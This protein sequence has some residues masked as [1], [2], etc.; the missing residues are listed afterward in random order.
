MKSFRL[1]NIKAFKDS[2]EIELK[3]ITI[4]VGKNSCGK[5][6]LLRFP[7]VLSQTVKE[8]EK[9][10]PVSFYGEL[11]DY[12][13]LEDI[14]HGKTGKEIAFSVSYILDVSE[15]SQIV[16]DFM[17][18]RSIT[19]RNA[20][21]NKKKCTLSVVLRRNKKSIKV[22]KVSVEIEEN[23]L[24]Q[25][26]YDEV[27]ERFVFNLFSGNDVSDINCTLNFNK[28]EVFFE[29]FFPVYDCETIYVIAR[30]CGVDL[31]EEQL[32][33]ISYNNYLKTKGVR[34]SIEFSEQENKIAK[35]HETFERAAVIMEKLYRMYTSEC[36]SKVAYIGPFR[37]NPGRIYRYSEASR[38]HVGAKGENVGDILVRAYNKKGE[39]GLFEKI[40]KWVRDYYGYNLIIKEMNK[41]YFQVILKDTNGLEANIIDVGF[42]ISQVLP[43]IAEMCLS[44]Q[45]VSKKKLGEVPYEINDILLIEQPELHLHPAAQ[46]SIAE[47]LNM[48]VL[49]N[50]NSRIIVETHSEHL[51]SK[52]QVLIADKDNPLTNE[53]V[54]VLYVDK[55]SSGE[56]FV[57]KMMIKENG[58][59]EKEWPT[60]FF[61]QG[62]NLSYEL[63]KKSQRREQET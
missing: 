30:E 14:V 55:T 31:E 18:I 51:I 15:N 8:S 7:A 46:A 60:G 40:T 44:S 1:R 42:G 61:D 13:N 24:S 10:P 2:G 57:E 5:S 29:K 52:L 53:M 9:N 63:M 43:I 32:R 20:E 28:E 48:C 39:S 50:D 37:E 35:I 27:N 21:I 11:L 49:E 58:K 38:T 4:L 6:S 33:K 45:K 16:S 3:P 23:N 17:G 36:K 25:L 19:K 26:E 62:L 54:Q 47:L 59:F 12:G 34:N 41:N 56:A 22:K